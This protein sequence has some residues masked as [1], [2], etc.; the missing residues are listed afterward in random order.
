MPQ[1]DIVDKQCFT[2]LHEISQSYLGVTSD[3]PQSL[4]EALGILSDYQ[5]QELIA[6]Q[7]FR[8]LGIAHKRKKYWGEPKDCQ[9]QF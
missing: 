9:S 8:L 7:R 4:G 2:F 5:M 3:K 1:F 6:E